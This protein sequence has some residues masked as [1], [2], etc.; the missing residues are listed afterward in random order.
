MHGA[1]SHWKQIVAEMGS[2]VAN[3]SN[4]ILIRATDGLPFR[5]ANRCPRPKGE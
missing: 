3:S 4:R 5:P 2:T 1:S